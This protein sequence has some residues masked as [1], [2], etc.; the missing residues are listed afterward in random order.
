M[1]VFIT[2]TGRCGTLTCAKV[3]ESWPVAGSWPGH[4]RPR[5]VCYMAAVAISTR[6]GFV[7]WRAPTPG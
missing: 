4:L 6:K 2:G 7:P 1:R 5:S 3:T